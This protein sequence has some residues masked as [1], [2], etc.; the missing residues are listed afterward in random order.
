V[1]RCFRRYSISSSTSNYIYHGGTI[2]ARQAFSRGFTLNGAFTFGK[3]LDDAD[4]PVNTANYL[5]VANRRLDRGLAGFDVVRK[6]AIVSVW[7][8]PFLRRQKGL[9]PAVLGGWQ[10]SGMA[11]FQAA[12]PMNVTN[13]AAW[14]SG[15]FNGDGTGGDRP[16]PP[17]PGRACRHA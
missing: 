6:L 14:P 11:I 2:Q 5:D 1:S 8:I 3:T 16:S 15:D 17:A 9:V 4:D 10:L 13:S 7:D 12:T